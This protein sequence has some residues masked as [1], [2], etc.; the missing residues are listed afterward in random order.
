MQDHLQLICFDMVGV[1]VRMKGYQKMLDWVDGRMTREQFIH[2][3]YHAPMVIDFEAG[4][5]GRKE[6]AAFIVRELR[7]P[8]EVDDFLA[9][10]TAW[11][12]GPFP[13]TIGVLKALHGKMPLAILSNSNEVYGEKLPAMGLLEFFDHTFFSH[14]TGLL[15]P[16]PKA[17]ALVVEQTGVP[18]DK[19]VFFDDTPHNVEAAQQFGFQ[20]HLTRGMATVKEKLLEL[21]LLPA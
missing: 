3:W 12:Y 20:A 11:F 10:F 1:L 4:R 19:I 21:K 17:F 13:E 8:I 14:L 9:A 15:K 2:W 6:F 5:I 7:L 16:D 18:A